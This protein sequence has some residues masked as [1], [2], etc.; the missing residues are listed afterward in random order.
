MSGYNFTDRVRRALVCAREE[1]Q[2]LSHEAVGPEHVLL[3]VIKEG[4][5]VAITALERLHIDLEGLR[6]RIMAKAPPGTVTTSG[7]DIPYTRRGKLV[8]ELAMEEARDLHHEYVGTEHLLLGVASEEKGIGAQVLK[9][10]GADVEVLRAQVVQ[11]LG[12]PTPPQPRDVLLQR[13][14]KLAKRLRGQ[15][16]PDA[17]QVR[18]IAIELETIIEQLRSQ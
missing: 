6:A 1:A 15:P 11:L 10:M 5:G 18:L 9:E 7:P 17:A 2:R 4:N 3:G 14:A 12:Q 13:A 16:P 8:L